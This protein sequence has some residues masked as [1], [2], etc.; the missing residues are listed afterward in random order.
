MGIA[1]TYCSV[2]GHGHEHVEAWAS[3]RTTQLLSE[4]TAVEPFSV[5]S[6][7]SGAQ[8][9]STPTTLLSRENL[10]VQLLCMFSFSFFI[11][12]RAIDIIKVFL[13]VLQPHEFFKSSTVSERCMP[14]AFKI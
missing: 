3:R 2:A 7:S 5:K 8:S 1:L 9:A 13:Y 12:L 14:K 6:Y 4:H 10:E 11:Y